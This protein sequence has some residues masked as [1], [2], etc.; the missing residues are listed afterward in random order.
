MTCG[1]LVGNSVLTVLVGRLEGH[2]CRGQN[3][4]AQVTRQPLNRLRFREAA[5]EAREE[6]REVGPGICGYVRNP[7]V[8][9]F[10]RTDDLFLAH[11]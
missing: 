4:A 7:G 5:A 2:L 11:R 6:E 8:W 10:R 9:D 3:S 1:L